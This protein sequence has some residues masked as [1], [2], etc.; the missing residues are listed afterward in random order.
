MP[1]RI[2][3]SAILGYAERERALDSQRH[4]N[5][6][7]VPHTSG[8]HCV[9]IEQPPQCNLSVISTHIHSRMISFH[10]S[11]FLFSFPFFI[12]SSRC[13]WDRIFICSALRCVSYSQRNEG[14]GAYLRA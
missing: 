1:R 8:E 6:R 10:A 9:I 14:A 13:V 11:S 5:T 4:V 3:G 2:S 7:F 12:Y